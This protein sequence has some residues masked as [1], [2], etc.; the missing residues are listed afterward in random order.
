MLPSGGRRM[1]DSSNQED[2]LLDKVY[3]YLTGKRYAD[4]ITYNG[5]RIIRRKASKFIVSDGEMYVT[6][7]RK[8]KVC[9][10]SHTT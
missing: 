7:K 10:A 6:K 2:E 4:G 3:L 9:H 8:G 1:A 5:K